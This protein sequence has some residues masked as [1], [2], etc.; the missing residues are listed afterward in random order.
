MSIFYEVKANLSEEDVKA[1]SGARIKTIQPGIESLATSTLQLMKKGS[2]VFHNL[3]LL[4][5]CVMHD[6]Y[7]IWNLL[8]G[9]PGE[10]EEVYKDYIRWMPFLTHLPP[11]V[12]VFPVRFDRY[13]PY[14]MQKNEYGLE[15]RPC[16]FYELTYPFS[17]E[18]LENLAYY[19]T[20]HNFGAQYN[21]KMIKWIGKIRNKFDLWNDLWFSGEPHAQPKLFLSEKGNSSVVYDSRS[22]EVLEYDITEAGRQILQLLSKP[23]KMVDIDTNLNRI[24]G[25]D[26]EKEFALLQS[27]GLV[28]NEGERFV[29]LVLPKEPPIMQ[30]LIPVHRR[31]IA[32]SSRPRPH[33][34]V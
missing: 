7:P 25:Y 29:S 18:T 12:G 9:F 2:T 3:L 1:L 15:L 21:E 24:H 17:Q 32:A 6:I 28:F 34:S 23:N 30:S 27:R 5:Y 19:F 22:G 20:D 11:P 16:D 14:F 26:L 13:S 4:K 10:I 31:R 33:N 8:V